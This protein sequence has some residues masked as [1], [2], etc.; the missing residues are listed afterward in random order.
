[1]A[2]NV[3]VKGSKIIV[4]IDAD[5]AACDEAPRSKGGEGKT[6]LLASISEKVRVNGQEVRVALNAMLPLLPNQ[7]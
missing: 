1:M 3:T 7:K 5:K 4:E 6:R 2:T